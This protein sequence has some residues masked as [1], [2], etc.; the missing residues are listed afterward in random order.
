MFRELIIILS[1]TYIGS[2]L[3]QVLHIPLPSIIV[4]MGMMFFLLHKKYLGLNA[5]EKTTN[6]LLGN[7]TILFLPAVVK[8]YEFLPLLK[9]DFFK[10]IILMIFTTVLAIVITSKVV[11][12][13]IMRKGGKK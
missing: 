11:N 6:F 2:I 10:I 12:V 9:K 3:K 8:M 1:I 5:I 13:L 7:M 4:S